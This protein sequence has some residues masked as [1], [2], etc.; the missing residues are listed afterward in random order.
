MK[1]SSH[2]GIVAR[3]RRAE[4]HLRA[5]VDM[6]GAE[7]DCVAIA[8]QLHAVEAAIAKAKRELIQDHIE[9]CLA[10]A[11]G[12]ERSVIAELKAIAKFL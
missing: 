10:E 6:F 12:S 3:L 9:Y 1:H 5:V 7:R 11:P 4:G 8:Q 2:A